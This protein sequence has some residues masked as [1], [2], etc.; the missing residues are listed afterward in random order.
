MNVG[1]IDSAPKIITNG[2]VLHLDAAQ[3]RSYSGTGT[4][5][6][7]LS[8][9]GNNGTLVNNPT[10][11][12]ANGGSIVFDG[13]NDYVNCGNSSIIDFNGQKNITVAAWM[14][15]LA[16][17]NS[18]ANII[19]KAYQWYTNFHTDRKIRVGFY[20]ST[21]TFFTFYSTA[22]LTLNQWYNIVW[23]YNGINVRLYINT[24]LDSTSAQTSNI[25]SGSGINCSLLIGAEANFCTSPETRYFN[26]RISGTQVYN[27]ALSAAEVLQ[28]YN[29]T[30][31]RFG[32]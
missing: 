24:T 5:W 28:N 19:T 27:R 7:D 17:T 15:P 21:S 11:N 14:Y 23:T 31:S 18:N 10:F 32:L 4:V 9:N 12:S 25:T 6:T 3:K 22:V 16:A 8:G 30:K 2:L 1:I 20:T 26:G 29:A 13:T